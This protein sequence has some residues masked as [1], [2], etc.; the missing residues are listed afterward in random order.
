MLASTLPKSPFSRNHRLRDALG[1]AIYDAMREDGAIHLFGEGC[2]VKVHYDA[3]DIERDFA[4]R[5]H[6]L[7]ISEDGNLNFA[8]GASLLGVKPVVDVIGADFL[9][10]CMDSLCNTAAKLNFVLG[11]S[12][13]PST[14][15]VRAEFQV[16]GPTTGQRPEALFTHI[17]GLRVAIPS[18]PRDA[19]GLMRKA[20]ESPGVS[21]IFEDRMIGDGSFS[22]GDLRLR[23]RVAFGCAFERRNGDINAVLTIVTYGLMRQVT[24]EALDSGLNV[25]L[26]DLRSL[27]PVDW[28]QIMGSLQRTRRLLIVEPDVAYGGVGAEIAAHFAERM[29]GVRIRRLGAPRE[30]IPASVHLHPRMMPAAQEIQEAVHELAGE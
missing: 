12:G 30:T 3:P 22:G 6:T 29:P 18:T 27:Y 11:P 8:V 14:I 13:T 23:E 16:S 17:P 2:E 26:F 10:R 1:Q 5:C 7:P 9:Y 24:E 15:V 25:D 28:T 19:Y 20:L 21:L 4:A